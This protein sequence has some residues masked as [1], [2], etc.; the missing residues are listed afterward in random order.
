MQLDVISLATLALLGVV[1]LA[2]LAAL[3]ADAERL[4]RLVRD[5]LENLFGQARLAELLALQ[6]AWERRVLSAVQLDALR[7]IGG[8]IGVL[9]ALALLLARQPTPLALALGLLAGGLGAAY[10]GLAFRRGLLRRDIAAAEEHVVGFIV[11]L[12]QEATLGTP[13]EQA[14]RT[15]VDTQ[16]NA[17]AELLAGMPAG[18]GSDPIA[19]VCEMAVRSGS[20]IFLPVAASLR[21]LRRARDPRLVLRNMEDRARLMLVARLN[22]ENAQRRLK[23]LML[24][25]SLM[26]LSILA[27]IIVPLILRVT[28]IT[29]FA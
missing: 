3:L 5:G 10:P 8:G 17:L 28:A 13:V 12:R 22:E 21:S 27:L 29:Q 2:A 24:T 11:H 18:T 1:A 16:A 15:Y 26:L 25:V 19:G 6:E 7:V 9:L 14:I 23:V 4:P 20:L